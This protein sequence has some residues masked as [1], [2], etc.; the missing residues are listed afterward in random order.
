MPLIYGNVLLRNWQ[1]FA[2]ARIAGFDL[3]GHFWERVRLDMPVSIGR[4]RFAEGP[5]DPVLLQ[6]GA[7]VLA[8]AAGEPA[9]EQ[10]NAGRR[11]MYAL[12]FEDMERETR[13]TL[14]HALGSYGFDAA[15]D[16][17]AITLNRW[18]HGY[19]YEYMR[20]WDSF[21]PTGPLPIH[22]AR[23]RWGRVVFANA[24]AGAFAYVQGAIDQATRAVGELLPNARLPS[25]ERQPGPGRR[26][27]KF[28]P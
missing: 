19:A 23:A 25:F 26:H 27:L 20:P 16:I 13:R 6:M 12:R 7:V 24:D 9:R 2:Q 17:E 28:E 1:A 21:W 15:R 3:P 10:A 14:N 11:L 8:G 4:Y 22:V 18:A 5:Q